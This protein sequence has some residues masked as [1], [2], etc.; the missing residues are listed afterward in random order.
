MKYKT[1]YFIFSEKDLEDAFAPYLAFLTSEVKTTCLQR[2]VFERSEKTNT[3]T[4]TNTVCFFVDQGK[5]TDGTNKL[6]V[7][8]YDASLRFRPFKSTQQIKNRLKRV[9]EP[10]KAE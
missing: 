2:Y 3:N 4:N 7:G 10:N 8:E 5:S 6:R 1:N 9:L